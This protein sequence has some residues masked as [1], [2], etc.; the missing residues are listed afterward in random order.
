MLTE[1]LN[2]AQQANALDAI[3]T[4]EVK[5]ISL[6]LLKNGPQPDRVFTK[7]RITADYADFDVKAVLQS[8]DQD[9]LNIACRP[10]V[11]LCQNTPHSLMVKCSVLLT[12][13]DVAKVIATR[14]YIDWR[15]E[16]SRI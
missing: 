5:L 7:S 1:L 8:T 13:I 16:V 11:A 6:T 2:K 9:L 12:G 10:C 14:Q 4:P 3:S 15:I